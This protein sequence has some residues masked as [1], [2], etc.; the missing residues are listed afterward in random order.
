[1]ADVVTVFSNMKLNVTEM[2]ARDNDE[3]NT[4]FFLTVTVSG[5]EQLELV[6]NRLRR[7]QGV[8]LVERQMTGGDN[9]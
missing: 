3:G 6:M 8:S 9:K 7:C 5:L 2:N 1:M 4:V